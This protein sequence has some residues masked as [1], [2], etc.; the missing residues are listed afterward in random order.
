[1]VLRNLLCRE[2]GL[3][4]LH[5]TGA[6]GEIVATLWPNVEGGRHKSAH[7]PGYPVLTTLGN[8]HLGPIVLT[9]TSM[10]MWFELYW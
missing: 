10:A 1:M 2:V 5:T 7:R 4:I 3:E 6:T 8:S 9:V